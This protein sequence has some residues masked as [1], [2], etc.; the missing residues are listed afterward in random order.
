MVDE[1]DSHDIEDADDEGT[2][3]N[4]FIEEHNIKG[5]PYK[6]VRGRILTAQDKPIG[7][8]SKIALFVG[9]ALCFATLGLNFANHRWFN[10]TQH[11]EVKVTD[12]MFFKRAR[13]LFG[14]EALIRNFV[15]EGENL[16]AMQI[17]SS[18]FGTKL[19]VKRYHYD[20]H[21]DI[22]SIEDWV[23]DEKSKRLVFDRDSRV[24]T[25]YNDKDWYS[26]RTFHFAN[27]KLDELI[28]AYSEHMEKHHSRY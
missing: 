7:R 11:Y 6:E 2:E 17:S 5:D 12:S 3:D 16:N 1:N 19:G 24:L 14:Y 28:D 22:T 18:L 9:G 21:Y 10:P 27:K 13:G 26:R 25:P 20:Y 8:K 15:F 4:F 23:Y